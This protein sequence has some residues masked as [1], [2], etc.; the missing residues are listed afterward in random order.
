MNES[1]V[2]APPPVTKEVAVNIA[3]TTT[4][5]APPTLAEPASGPVAAM[6]GALQEPDAAAAPNP[7]VEGV[8]M[9]NYIPVNYFCS[10]NH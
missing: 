8:C 10:P 3:T 2:S 6:S 4:E 5:D 9:S 1:S 7:S